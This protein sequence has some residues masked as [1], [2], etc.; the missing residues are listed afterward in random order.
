M[1][2]Y[3]KFGLQALAIAAFAIGLLA[4]GAQPTAAPVATTAPPAA[5]IDVDI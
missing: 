5:A 4:C 2:K 3:R 1:T